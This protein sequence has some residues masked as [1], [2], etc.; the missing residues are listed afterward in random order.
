MSGKTQYD[1]DRIKQNLVPIVESYLGPPHKTEGDRRIYCCPGCKGNAFNLNPHYNGRPIIGCFKD[2]C[3]VERVMD[4]LNFV[5]MMEQLNASRD[6]EEVCKR[7]AEIVPGCVLNED[8]ANSNKQNGSRSP[9]AGSKPSGMATAGGSPGGS[10]ASYEQPR[11]EDFRLF[12]H[13]VLSELMKQCPLNKQAYKILYDRGLDDDTILD[14]RFGFFRAQNGNQVVKHLVS[15]F[16]RPILQAP[17]FS[18]GDKKGK[19]RFTL[20]GHNWLL[21]PYYDAEG[22][23]TNVEGRITPEEESQVDEKYMALKNSGSHLY[24]FPGMEHHKIDGICEGVFGAAVAAQH[25]LNIASIQGF[26]RYRRSGG[27]DVLEELA[28]VDFGGEEVVF[29]PDVDYPPND[30]VMDEAPAAAHWLIEKQN[31]LPKIAL[32]PSGKDLDEYMRS[33]SPSQAVKGMRSLMKD[34]L[35]PKVYEQKRKKEK[36]SHST[37]TEASQDQAQQPEVEQPPT[38]NDPAPPFGSGE[39]TPA[40][41]PNTETP[42]LPDLPQQTGSYEVA[43]SGAPAHEPTEDENDLLR[44]FNPTARRA[45]G[46]NVD[47]RTLQPS[48]SAEPATDDEPPSPRQLLWM[49]YKKVYTWAQSKVTGEKVQLSPE[50]KV[51]RII[52]GLKLATRMLVVAVVGLLLYPLASAVVSL[53]T[54]VTGLILTAASFAAAASLPAL[55]FIYA[56]WRRHCHQSFLRGEWLPGEKETRADKKRRRK[57]EKQARKV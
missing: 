36:N 54:S 39:Q 14:G 26:R 48:K 29:F 10:A 41:D 27:Q 52:G 19:V 32:L 23:L 37:G 22:Y 8:G 20:L 4:S 50:Q 2:K 33:L 21:I 9:Q 44:R 30:E 45:S 28:G 17:G 24:V 18:Q 38:T 40:N 31:G 6:F 53:L 47:Q 5:A 11:I 43:G 51:A 57:K 35:S 42:D 49:L 13:Q 25:G 3:D 12:R 15:K 34:A 1:K 55:I 16:R 7:A 46:H 56:A